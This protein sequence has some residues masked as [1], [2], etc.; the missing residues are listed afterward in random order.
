MLHLA[1]GLLAA[2]MA[3]FF[4]VEALS[5]MMSIG[6]LMSYCLVSACT[7]I[8]R[9]REPLTGANRAVEVGLLH[10]MSFD[11]DA[12][13]EAYATP[14]SHGQSVRFCG[15]SVAALLSLFWGAVAGASAIAVNAS[16]HLMAFNWLAVTP[17]AVLAVV[18]LLAALPLF[19]MRQP[20][21]KV[22]NL[23]PNKFRLV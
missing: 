8:L 5:H 14:A 13:H 21:A 18:A 12:P 23:T 19:C 20:G 10:R 6:T 7:L 17:F 3:L 4:D 2:V 16:E 11:P 22:T 9:Y 1:L 15:L